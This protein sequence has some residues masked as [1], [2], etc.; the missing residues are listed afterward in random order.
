MLT[1]AI[2]EQT[3]AQLA[4]YVALFHAP[5]PPVPMVSAA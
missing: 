4:A 2:G 3:D 5:N 1:L